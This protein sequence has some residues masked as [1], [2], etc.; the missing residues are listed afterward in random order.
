MERVSEAIHSLRFTNDKTASHS[1][2]SNR[3]REIQ[4]IA[5]S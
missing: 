1:R 3:L 5:E 4:D 2:G